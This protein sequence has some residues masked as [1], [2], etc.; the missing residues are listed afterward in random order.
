MALWALLSAHAAQTVPASVGCRIEGE[1]KV[2]VLMNFAN[3]VIVS[4][5]YEAL[6]DRAKNSDQSCAGE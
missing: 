6:R 2:N 1:P 5:N 4:E 3:L